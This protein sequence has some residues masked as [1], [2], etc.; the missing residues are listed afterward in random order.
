VAALSDADRAAIRAE[1]MVGESNERNSVSIVKA[2]IR[3]AINALDDFFEA[4]A[5]TINAAIPQPAR[6]AMT[7]RQKNKMGA[8]V[9]LKRAERTA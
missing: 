5:A 6:G 4:Q 3:A 8:M 9:L 2:D 1:F 7:A